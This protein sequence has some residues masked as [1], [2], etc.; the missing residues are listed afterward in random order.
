M[1][2]VAW[3]ARQKAALVAA[4]VHPLDAESVVAWV[5]QNLPIGQ[6]PDT[7]QPAQQVITNAVDDVAIRDAKAYWYTSDDVPQRYRMIL[8]ATPV[9]NEDDGRNA[10]RDTAALLLYLFL[11]NRQQYYT[12]R[13]FRPISTINV[14]S[15]LDGSV[16]GEERALVDLVTALHDGA[17]SPAAW[18][19]HVQTQLRRLHL[20]Y[21]A[22]GAGGYANMSPIDLANVNAELMADYNRLHAFMRSIINEQS[23]IA[24]SQSRIQMYVGNARQQYWSAFEQKLSPD[25]GYA[26]IERRL[27][28]PVRHCVDCLGFYEQGWQRLNTLPV[29][30]RMC[31][32]MTNCRCYKVYRQVP[33][34]DLSYWI[35]TRRAS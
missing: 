22:L 7:W 17:I 27:L 33:I 18:T 12:V 19:Q 29:P 24:Q 10:G 32:C 34:S 15:L 5:T 3:S 4:G 26:I 23:T 16:A 20:N 8:N 25:V 28:S 21:R 35:G 13:P 31:Q 6:D 11:R 30:G 2:I 14:R 9:D 1:D